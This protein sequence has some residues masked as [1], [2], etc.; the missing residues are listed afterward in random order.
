MCLYHTGTSWI[1]PRLEQARAR[2]LLLRYGYF[3]DDI[4]APGLRRRRER[5]GLNDSSLGSLASSGPHDPVPSRHRRPLTRLE[6]LFAHP[7]VRYAMA[8]SPGQSASADDT[9]R[10]LPK[11]V[12]Q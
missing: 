5:F 9:R 12:S 11:N 2:S 7:T 4:L 3:H 10:D 8:E 6:R 1:K